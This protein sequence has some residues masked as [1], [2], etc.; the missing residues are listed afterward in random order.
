MV[1]ALPAAVAG[2]ADI[3][4]VDT[5][6]TVVWAGVAFEESEAWAAHIGAVWAANGD[7]DSSGFLFRAQALYVGWEFDPDG[8]G[9]IGR[10]NLS[11]GYQFAGDGVVASVFAGIDYQDVDVDPDDDTDLDDELGVIFTGRIAT[12]GSTV[13]PMSLEGNYS[14]A[15]DSYWA[16]ARIGYNFDWFTLGPEL[17]VLGDEGLDAFRIGGYTA[18]NLSDGVILDLNAGYHDADGSANSRGSD[19]GFYGGATVVFVF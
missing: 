13:L 7:L 3:E 1:A 11:V 14:T 16:R 15:N 4:P 5:N 8:D 19:D 9:E 18:V 17:A 2:A 12:N 10:G 6:S